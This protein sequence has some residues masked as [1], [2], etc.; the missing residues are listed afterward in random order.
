MRVVETSADVDAV[1]EPPRA[2]LPRGQAFPLAT[3]RQFNVSKPVQQPVPGAG[4]DV[5][6]RDA[7]RMFSAMSEAEIL[8]AQEQI[9][10]NAGAATLAILQRR[11]AKA[12]AAAGETTA[13]LPTVA[14]AALKKEAVEVER[15][16]L[17]PP[18]EHDKLAWTDPE[19]KV[20]PREKEQ[21]VAQSLRVQAFRFGLKGEIIPRGTAGPA[22]YDAGLHH[23]GEEYDEAGYTLEEL[24]TLLRSQ[25]EQQNVFAAQIVSGIFGQIVAGNFSH[26]QLYPEAGARSMTVGEGIL[27][28]ILGL[29]LLVAFRLCFFKRSLVL[30]DVCRKTLPLVCVAYADDVVLTRHSAQPHWGAVVFPNAPLFEDDG[31]EEMEM[32]DGLRSMVRQLDYLPLMDPSTH[33]GLDCLVRVAGH[34]RQ[35]AVKLSTHGDLVKA[36]VANLALAS[37]DKSLRLLRLMLSGFNGNLR[38]LREHNVAAQCWRHLLVPINNEA[39]LEAALLLRVMITF[40]DQVGELLDTLQDL[41]K[42]AAAKQIPVGLVC[43]LCDAVVVHAKAQRGAADG[44]TLLGATLATLAQLSTSVD[45]ASLLHF[46]ATLARCY[47]LVTGLRAA[48]AATFG[49]V[50]RT[51][52]DLY[53]F[54]RF[55]NASE[56]V[57]REV[58]SWFW[59]M[60]KLNFAL[61]APQVQSDKLNRFK[62]Q[63]R[64]RTLV[65]ERESVL[66]MRELLIGGCC[67]FP[68]VLVA[69]G[70][71]FDLVSRLALIGVD[72]WLLLDFFERVLLNAVFIEGVA[73]TLHGSGPYNA[74]DSVVQSKRLCGALLDGVRKAFFRDEKWVERGRSVAGEAVEPMPQDSAFLS[75]FA[76]SDQLCMGTILGSDWL[77]VLAKSDDAATARSAVQF[78]TLA[79]LSGA[80]QSLSSLS[81]VSKLVKLCGL[82]LAANDDAPSFQDPAVAAA[83]HTL[84]E[85]YSGH[86]S[87]QALDDGLGDDDQ[88]NPMQTATDLVGSFVAHGN[89]SPVFAEFIFFFMRAD[90]PFDF[91]LLVWTSLAPAWRLLRL[92]QVDA[93]RHHLFPA[94]QNKKVLGAMEEALRSGQ[95]TEKGNA[96]VFWLAVHHLAHWAFGTS[97]EE[98]TRLQL[99]RR[100][101][102][103]RHPRPFQVVLG[104]VYRADAPFPPT[105][106]A[107]DSPTLPERAALVAKL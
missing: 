63:R 64:T 2:S 12:A 75:L 27:W 10:R 18:I 33:W 70:K 53:A 100:L 41:L 86:I 1:C 6:E 56:E 48:V 37:A 7:E 26:Q 99:L 19:T 83:L 55:V 36:V 80:T 94:E 89:N 62:T 52:G 28:E 73:R 105:L 38:L 57:R 8:E 92:G 79:E 43:L 29:R 106:N 98:W 24:V 49:G 91:R 45:V 102:E 40:D 95:L 13:F 87:G 76:S 74:E 17:L 9:R 47:P 23:H 25:N 93:R 61:S 78:L 42:R 67:C 81:Y 72:E 46:A 34:S 84:L 32:R 44:L 30:R 107:A 104:Y 50:E 97:E 60:D 14:T 69:F 59:S 35:S 51:Q 103:S 21:D 11:A 16:L 22:T 66:L 96:V 101:K 85:R 3:K 77:F 39:Q 5:A 15:E 4:D 31:S 68:N 20:Q 88:F 82:F 71:A 58:S 54:L 90:L 65:G